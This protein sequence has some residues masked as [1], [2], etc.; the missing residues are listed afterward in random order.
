MD[1]I[2]IRD[3]FKSLYEDTEPTEDPFLEKPL[4]AHY[5]SIRVLEDMLKT[6]ELWFSNPLYMNDW[7][8]VRFVISQA[9][10]LFHENKDITSACQTQARAEILGKYFYHYVLEFENKHLVDTY[11]FCLSKHR[12]DD[13]DGLLS[14]WRGYGGNG[15]GVAI[16]FD[17]AQLEHVQGSPLIISK[18]IYATQ[19]QRVEWLKKKLSDFAIIL[20]K[21]KVPDEKLYLPAYFLFQ[22]IKL[23]A[24]FTKHTGFCEEKEWRVVYLIDRDTNNQLTQMCNY[25]IGSR[26]IEPKL[27]FKVAPIGGIT[28]DNLSLSK[29]IERVILGP[30]ISSP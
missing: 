26:G 1:D 14:M 10:H 12:K 5:T 30:S 20:Q 11:V 21:I 6:N 25:S 17:T 2:V 16:V 18:V 3:Y 23:C 24:L 13:H 19:E 15:N 7:E 4:L 8:E 22:R 9:A 28:P 29:I 27:Q